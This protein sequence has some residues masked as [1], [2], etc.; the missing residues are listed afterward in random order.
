MSTDI[1]TEVP[2]L[3]FDAGIPGFPG[4][5]EF[6]LVTWQDE[7]SPF[8]IMMCVDGDPLEFLVVPPMLFFPDYAPEIDDDVAERIE[9]ET[10]EDALLLVIVTV[11]EDATKATANLL[12]PIIVNRHSRHALQ[13][14]L[15]EGSYDLRAPLFG[16]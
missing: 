8:S 1:A 5:H 11:P 13:A 14:V 12:A 3:R 2:T 4:A 10:A 7:D 6:A 9:L 16:G 15:A